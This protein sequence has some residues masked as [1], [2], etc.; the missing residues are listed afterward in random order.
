M[1]I[2]DFQSLMRPVLAHLADGDL[3]RSREV[4]EAMSDRF[5][6]SDAERA[7][8]LPSG[9]QRTMDNRVGWSLTYLS[10]AGLVERP[11]RGQVRITAEGRVALEVNPSRIDMHVLERYPAYLEFR[12]RTRG[13]RPASSE[14]EPEVV[15]PSPVSPQDLV[16]R[17]VAENRAAMEGELLKKALAL[18]PKGFEL[19]VLRLLAAMGYGK[20]GGLIDH[21]GRSGDG[22]IDGIISQDPLGL[23]RIYLQ[24]KRYAPELSVGRPTI[25]GFVGALV[26]AQGDR[27]VFLTTSRFTEGARVEADRVAYRIEL[28]DGKRL[29]ELMLRHGVGVQVQTEVRLYDLDEDFF[30]EL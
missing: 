20:N 3:H 24:A 10:Q 23:D 26:G 13:E 22:G 29:A 6:L 15:S 21:A 5:E 7:E 19:L 8:L 30:E 2:P 25:Q 14:G 9:R 12:D 11:A 18:D 4:K 17:A 27:G 16:D 28:I 1:T